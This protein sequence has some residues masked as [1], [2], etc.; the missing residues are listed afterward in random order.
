MADDIAD[1]V[2]RFSGGSTKSSTVGNPEIDAIVNR[3]S[4]SDVYRDPETNRTV[5]KPSKLGD[6][7]LKGDAY[8]KEHTAET[9]IQKIENNKKSLGQKFGEFDQKLTKAIEGNIS[10]KYQAGKDLAAE[11]LNE[12]GLKG[13][14]K[15][16]LGTLAAVT[17]PLG[18]IDEIVNKPLTNLTGDPTFGDKAGLLASMAVPIPG[19]GGRNAIS[20]V[21]SKLPRNRAFQHLV[22]D[23]QPQNIPAV[24]A[25][26]K[27]N[28]RLSLMDVSPAVR[29]TAQQLAVN[30]KPSLNHLSN[31]V[32][33]RINSAPDAASS[34]YDVLGGQ[35]VNPVT[36]LNELKAAARKAG[37][38]QIE[39]ALKAAKPVNITPVIEH[40]DSQLKPGVNSVIT[41]GD[42]LPH[43]E[44]SKYLKSFRDFIT[45]DKSFRVNAS[46]LHTLQSNT[47]ETAQHL[48]DSSVGHD[49]LMGHALM[50]TRNK[51]VD[52][53]D[54]S[55]PGYKSGLKAFRDE[56]QIDLAFNDAYKDVM[57]NSSKLQE[58]PE[59]F[60]VWVDSLSDAEKE[61]AK[62]GARL[63]ID[64][65]INKTKNSR[66]ASD[67]PQVNFKRDKLSHLF[68]K[69]EFDA[70]AK[71]MNDARTIAD[72]NHK[73][74]EASQTGFR[75]ASDTRLESGIIKHHKSLE[76]QVGP[77]LAEGAALYSGNAPFIGATYGTIKGMTA[78][79]DIVIRKIAENRNL[80]IAKMAS[81]S[82]GPMRDQLIR[83]LEAISS[84][85]PNSVV[86]VANKLSRVIAP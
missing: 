53:I 2:N 44:L 10:D 14:G 80:Q 47:R 46:S 74:L 62:E 1:I 69:E 43:P 66:V 52:A 81:A 72:T 30:S 65:A 5:I 78:A 18:I 31:V 24:V 64:T 13:V 39:P 25:E 68:G 33:Q 59:F 26:L 21:T 36:K 41:M 75:N 71:K 70:L 4:G 56:K 9:V 16:A 79:K 58:R 19:T 61:A 42:G 50:V 45:D 38:D 83:E 15:A 85:A 27:S 29:Q 67:I 17:S 54:K 84:P 12:G 20:A 82:D 37:T 76:S 34:A 35:V 57:S 23:I 77:L 86:R 40:I 32:E 49:R 11:G 7:N 55:A 28:P 22:E 6:P 3:F 60:K 73:L 51:M 48:L 63:A 8:S